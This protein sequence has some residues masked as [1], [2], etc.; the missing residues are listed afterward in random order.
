MDI[1]EMCICVYPDTFLQRS[2]MQF[3]LGISMN[4]FRALSINSSS[5]NFVST[6][7]MW[8]FTILNICISLLKLPYSLY[9]KKHVSPCLKEITVFLGKD[10][11]LENRRL[12][13]MK[14]RQTF[15]QIIQISKVFRTREEGNQRGH[16]AQINGVSIRTI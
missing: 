15:L 2:L 9:Q 5:L 3:Y 11:Q 4:A 16:G 13:V 12:Q 10:M 14:A 7:L 8:N 6:F 1:S